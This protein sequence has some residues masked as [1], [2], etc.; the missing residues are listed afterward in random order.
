MSLPNGYDKSGYRMEMVLLESTD[1]LKTWHV[2]SREPARFQHSAGSFAQARTQDGRFLRFVWSCYSLDPT[3]KPNEIFYQS[4]DNGKTWKKMPSFVDPHFATFSNRLRTLRDGTLVLA[5]PLTRRWGKDTDRPV[6]A[7]MRLDMPNDIEM[8][9]F[10]SHDQGRTWE[11][12]LPVLGG[13]NVS[14]TDFVELPSG[15]LLLINNNIFPHPGR[16]F[17]Y[18]DGNRFTPGPLESVHAG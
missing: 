6:R 1:D 13:Q 15:D 7:T 12:P 16:Q 10:F 2:L 17:I 11:G 9:L 4:T 8:T 18:R 14:E 5:L 3:V